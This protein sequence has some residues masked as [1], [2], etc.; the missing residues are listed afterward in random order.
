[1]PASY[2]HYRFGRMVLSALPASEKQCIQRFRRMFDMGLQGP[3]IFFFYNPLIKN[4]VAPLCA[5]YHRKSGAALFSAACA[6]AGSEAAR[7]Y[8]YGL[9]GHYCLDAACHPFIQQKANQGEANHVALEA[10]F[11]RYLLALDGEVAPHSWDMS[12]RLKLT[13]GECMTVA[14]FYP[15]VTGGKVSLSVRHMAL[16]HKYAGGKNR[17]RTEAILKKLKP[18]LQNGLIPASPVEAYARMDSEL[19]ARFNRAVTRYPGLLEQLLAHMGTG[20][21]LGEDFSPDFG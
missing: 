2:A 5:D 14:S 21:P 18:G 8:L 15:P 6:Q 12:P 11:D 10:E 1:M 4:S 19:L 16:L 7:A 20:E 3:D 9:L 13:R 17:P